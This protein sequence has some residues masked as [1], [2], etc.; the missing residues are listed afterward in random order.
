MI[1]E[2][3]EDPQTGLRAVLAVVRENGL[4]FGGT[5]FSAGSGVEEVV[6]LA[7]CMEAKLS[8]HR[9]EI[10]GAKAGFFCSPED[11]GLPRLMGL[12]VTAW[13][14]LLGERV[15]LG[16]DMGASNAL[17]SDLYAAAGLSQLGPL[18]D[19]AGP[20]WLRDFPG[21][22]RHMTGQGVCWSLKEVHG[23]TLEGVRVAIQGAGAVGLG[24]AVRLLREGAEI[25]AI[26]DIEHSVQL[27][28]G[29]SEEALLNLVEGGRIRVDSAAVNSCGPSEQ[30]FSLDVDAV[31]LA[32]S[33]NSVGAAAAKR[34]NG[35]CVVEGSNFGLTVEAREVLADRNL[36]VVPDLIASSASAAM[37]AH[38]LHTRGATAPETLWADIEACIRRE[39]REGVEGWQRRGE[40][41]R[42]RA[43]RKA[44]L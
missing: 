31:V 44:R 16:K 40:D 11:P 2:V 13:S 30:L 29:L 9:P 21:Y 43:F 5:R 14:T 6:E 3:V 36:L 8:P 28:N 10:G 4:S 34:I 37:V 33:S 12:A 19:S 17:I 18:R 27:H 25:V 23:G 38:Q 41:L 24:S 42:A 32:A 20:K 1:V 22:R 39:V 35:R 15:I 26:S 7:Q